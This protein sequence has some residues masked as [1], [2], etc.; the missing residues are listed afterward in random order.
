MTVLSYSRL[1]VMA[2]YIG[3]KVPTASQYR[4]RQKRHVLRTLAS[5]FHSTP[6]DPSMTA[7]HSA[8]M[9]IQSGVNHALNDTVP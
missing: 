7:A 1:Q 6:I 2:A 8:L 5:V 9:L 3:L 4:G